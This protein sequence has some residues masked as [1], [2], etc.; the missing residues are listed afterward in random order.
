MKQIKEMLGKKKVVKL[1]VTIL[2]LLENMVCRFR[3]F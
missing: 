3:N 1:A 2:V